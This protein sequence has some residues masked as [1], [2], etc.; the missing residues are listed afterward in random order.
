MIASLPMYATPL[1]A[2]SNARLWAGIRDELRATGLTAPNKLTLTPGDL[3]THWRDPALT[4]S[5]TC[6]MPYRCAL[7]DDVTLVGTPDYGVKGCPSGHYRS[8]IIARSDD[9]RDLPGFAKSRF[10]YNDA[11]SQSGWACVALELPELLG[12]PMIQTG[13]HRASAL[14]VRSG[15]ADF[16]AIDAVTWRLLLAANQATGLHV[17]HGTRPTPGLPFITSKEHDG[18]Q[19]F[20]T[21]KTA[22]AALSDADRDILGIRDIIA[23]PQTTYDLPLPPTPQAIST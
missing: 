23:L 3:L 17:I 10:A 19:I 5:Q 4:L 6:G 11:M 16:A 18:P 8:L 7:K 2:G 12:G 1:T 15:K 14:T 9:S 20:A 13:S 22:I 21:I